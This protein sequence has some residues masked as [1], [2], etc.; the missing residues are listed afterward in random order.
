MKAL[1]Q[2]YHRILELSNGAN[3]KIINIGIDGPTASGKTT[4]A[5]AL[6]KRLESEGKKVWVYQVDWALEARSKRVKDLEVLNQKPYAFSYEAE[7]HM[8][9]NIVEDFLK[10]VELFNETGENSNLKLNELYSRDHDGTCVGEAEVNLEPGMIIFYEGHYTLRTELDKYIDLNTVLLGGKEEFLQRKVDRVKS[11]RSPQDAIDYFWKIDVPSFRH[12]LRRYYSHADIVMDNTDYNNPVIMGADYCER[13]N[14]E[15]L[16]EELPVASINESENIAEFI[17]GS[18]ILIDENIKEAFLSNLHAIQKWDY[19]VGQYLRLS[20]DSIDKDLEE[21]AKELI[22]QENEKL[23]GSGYELKLTHTDSLFNVYNRVLPLSIAITLYDESGKNIYSVLAEVF[24]SKLELKVIWEGGGKRVHCERQ[25]GEISDNA[26]SLSFVDATESLY[27]GKANTSDMIEFATPSQFTIPSFLKNK[28]TNKVYIGK[29]EEVISPSSALSRLLE[30]GG[31]WVHRF[32]LFS[33]LRFYEH[34]LTQ[35]GVRTVSKGNYLIA[36][37]SSDNSLNLEFEAF[38]KEWQ[39]PLNRLNVFDKSEAAADAIVIRER[40][41]AKKEIDENYSHFKFRDGHLFA[42]FMYDQ[43]DVVLEAGAQLKKML[44]SDSRIVR[45]RANQFIEQF[46]PSLEIK[47]EELWSKLPK[48][49]VDKIS[50]QELHKLTP[51]IFAEVYLWQA[52]RG[53]E[54]AIL[55]ANIY[56]MR[57]TSIDS[58]SYLNTAFRRK[59]PIVLQASLNAIGQLE[60]EG[61]SSKQGYLM[62]KRGPEDFIQSVMNTVR[63]LYLVEGVQPELFGIGFD[64][65]SVEHDMPEGRAKRFFERGRE[66]G[67]L[68]HYVQDGASLFSAKTRQPDELEKSYNKMVDFCTSLVDDPAKC[69]LIDTEICAGELNYVED[70]D[71]AII[72]TAEEM[73]G[74]AHVYQ[75][76]MMETGNEAL[77]SRPLLFIGNMGTTHHGADV[78]IPEVEVGR[79]WKQGLKN[80][81]FISPVLH[82]TTNTHR[83]VLKRATAGC[84]KIN[85][86]GDLL[87]CM[88][89]HLP[90]KVNRII[91]DSGTDPK[92]MIASIRNL[93]NEFSTDEWKRIQDALEDEVGDIIDNIN[94]PVLSEMDCNYFHYNSYKYNERQ[95][96][97]ILESLWSEIKN[98]RQGDQEVKLASSEM[99]REFSSSMIEVPLNEFNTLVKPIYEKGIRHFHIDAGDGKFI[100]REFSGVEKAKKLKEMFDDVELHAHL[101]VEKPYYP[102]NGEK[103]AIQQYAEAGCDAIA[104]HPRAFETEEDLFN[105]LNLIRNLGSRPGILIETIDYFGDRLK[106]IIETANLDWVVV[107]GVPVGYGGQMFQ[108][109]TLRKISAIRDYANQLDRDFL[110]EVDGGMTNQTLSMAKN[111]GAQLFAGWSIIKDKTVDGMG[112]KIDEVRSILE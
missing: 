97:A 41:E 49:A 91:Q 31:V 105:S 51:T 24:Q 15:T 50:L 79:D 60:E 1:D 16:S 67:F 73:R 63:D 52:L 46:F 90:E 40:A 104:V 47:T 5:Q 29:E 59:Q 58:K 43:D 112:K 62:L 89:D 69:W 108:F 75:N 109:K 14:N 77:L 107:M 12:H 85:V 61:K 55:G 106:K 76:Q 38:S 2:F 54:S 18:T 56:D 99:N 78:S 34:L 11:Y 84:H 71:Q 6:K 88:V 44:L 111:A 81:N 4:M 83:D 10:K 42:K 93:M 33:E 3:G 72:P 80:E 66:T 53:D 19:Q 32:A 36:L 87:Y 64:H 86:A 13:W 23:Q 20:I 28:R 103:C 8:R 30:K 102:A 110:I 35:W 98:S 27:D 48:G 94:T 70:S 39:T 101:M 17:F 68:T 74:F 37:N 57:E 45:K 96:D 22:I 82:G 9:M 21:H 100:T 65:V 25:L 7:L 92:K 26:E 95:V